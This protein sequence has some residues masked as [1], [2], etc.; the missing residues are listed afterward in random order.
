MSIREKPAVAV[1]VVLDDWGFEAGPQVTFGALDRQV[2]ASLLLR[3]VIDIFRERNVDRL[4][5]SVLIA[6]LS[7]IEGRPW[8]GFSSEHFFRDAQKLARWLR[9][10]FVRPGTMRFADGTAKGYL[11]RD[12]ETAIKE[13]HAFRLGKGPANR[14]QTQPEKAAFSNWR[15]SAT[16]RS[17]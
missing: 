8:T 7:A 3:D 5:T 15:Q 13:Q 2:D 4:P 1:A 17:Y 12:F 11:R 14:G 6:D 10:L 9:P 16:S